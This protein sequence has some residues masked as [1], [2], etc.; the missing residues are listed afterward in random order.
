MKK[1][2]KDLSVLVK[3]IFPLLS[4]LLILLI[5]YSE[6]SSFEIIRK[7]SILILCGTLEHLKAKCDFI[8]FGFSRF[9]DCLQNLHTAPLCVSFGISTISK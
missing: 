5:D 6:T 2:T 4:V 8:S 1:R 3:S 9:H 7:Y